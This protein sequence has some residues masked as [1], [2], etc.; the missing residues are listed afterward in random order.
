MNRHYFRLSWR[1]GFTLAELLVASV[2]M[3]V[4]VLGTLAIYIRSHRIAVD[5]Q[6]IAELQHDVRT[7]MFFVSRDVRSAGVGLIP[8]V[9]GY[10]LEGY[11]SF[12][13]GD[14]AADSIK[15]MGN[16]DN[17][18]ALRIR[19]YQG[20]HGGG[21]ATA[22]L[23]DWELQ[24]A[25]YECPD[26]YE[27]RVVLILSTTCPGCFAF[28]YLS[29]NSV[30]GCDEGAEHVNMQ[31]GQSELNPPGG[32][33]DTGCGA[34]CWDDAIMTFGQIKQYWLDTTGSPGDYPSISSLDAEHGY[35]GIPNTLYLTTIGEQGGIVHY[36]LAQNIESIQ[37]QYNGDFDNNGLLDGFTDWIDSW[38]IQPGDDDA[39]RQSK[40][41]IISS[42]SQVRIW[43]L[44][45]TAEK[46][47]S[48]SGSPPNNIYLYRR[49][50]IANS[51][52]ASSDDMRR[53]VLLDS[54]VTIRNLALNL[55]NLGTR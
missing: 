6:R 46:M 1:K 16:F 47:T 43:V 22:F 14:E 13:P 4:V 48:V 12:S 50:P 33:V 37:F 9:S 54:T 5:Q 10:F 21:A 45:R 32:L 27:N 2:V 41:Q 39:A 19:Q 28:R 26:F 34:D 31:P 17:P 38:T 35:L 44:G 29:H 23:Y 7:A 55:Y 20:G 24:N 3:L 40:S 36:A 49:P 8:E 52:G 18:L 51:P 53:R 42:I 11:D 25:P 15:V 30:H